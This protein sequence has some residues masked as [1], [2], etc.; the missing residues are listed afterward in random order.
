LAS[1]ENAVEIALILGDVDGAIDGLREVAR[2]L[3]QGQD[4]LFYMYALGSLATALLFKADT[5]AAREALARAAPL[6][7][8]F[9]LGARYAATAALLAAQE[10]RMQAAARLLGY[11]DAAFVAHDLDA[12]LPAE[13]RARELTMQR[14]SASA[15]DSDI[16]EWKRRGAS[17]TVEEAYRLALAASP[18]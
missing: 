14:L 11:G 4:K 18:D 3:A 13:L 5:A 15:R 1:Q 8:R 9:D 2:R 16:E 7:V 17:L 12:Y 6:I 10:D